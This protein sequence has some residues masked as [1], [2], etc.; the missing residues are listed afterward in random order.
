MGVAALWTLHSVLAWLVVLGTLPALGAVLGAALPGRHPVAKRSIAKWSLYA[1]H[2]IVVAVVICFVAGPLGSILRWASVPAPATCL[3]W[4]PTQPPLL[5]LAVPYGLWWAS[6][7]AVNPYL[8]T[9]GWKVFLVHS[10][11]FL[12][13]WLL[14]TRV[15][16]AAGPLESL[17]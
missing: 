8:G 15:V 10:A 14:L 6:G 16:F 1:S 9:R 2:V 3:L 5:L 17:L 11:A 13:A 7:V 4:F 12:G